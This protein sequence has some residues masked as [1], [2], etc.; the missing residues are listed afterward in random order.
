[1]KVMLEN[2]LEKSGCNLENLHCKDWMVT[3]V[4]CLESMQET[5]YTLLMVDC[6]LVM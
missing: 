5:G 2:M 1:M 4:D 6:N 3:A